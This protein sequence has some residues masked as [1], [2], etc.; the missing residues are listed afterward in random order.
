MLKHLRYFLSPFSI[1]VA[2]F[3]VLKG[4]YYPLFFLIAFDVLIDIGDTFLKEDDK[5]FENPIP[6]ILNSA[7]YI[8]L[9]LLFLLYDNHLHHLSYWPGFHQMYLSLLH[10]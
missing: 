6:F 7:L 1:L 5:P 8:N 10:S 4:N 2:I 9:P 3:A